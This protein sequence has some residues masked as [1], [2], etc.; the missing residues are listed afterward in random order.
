MIENS[1]KWGF[2]ED[3]K[4]DFRGKKMVDVGCGVGGSSRYIVHKY[5]GSAVGL[6]LSPFQIA[7]ANELSSKMNL[8]HVLKYHVADAMNMPFE[9]NTF[10]LSKS[11]FL[12]FSLF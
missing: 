12:F 3:F 9:D 6:S 10:D 2:G 5:G 7:R 11:N 1:L 4:G 8:S